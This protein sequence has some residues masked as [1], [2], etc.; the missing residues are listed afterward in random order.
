MIALLAACGSPPPP[1]PP[2]APLPPSRAE[3]AAAAVDRALASL[4]ERT[5]QADEKLRLDVPIGLA[6]V[7]AARPHPR[8]EATLARLVPIVDHGGDPRRRAWDRTATWP[9]D[10]DYTWTP[11]PGRKLS[12]NYPLVEAMYCRSH[13]LRAE[14]V[15]WVCDEL[16]DDGGLLSGHAAWILRVAVDEGCLAREATCLDALRD[17][18][19]AGAAREVDLTDTLAR[20]TLG[21]QILF[22]L[23]AGAEPAAL[24]GAVDRL[25]AV[26]GEDGSFGAPGDA[27][28]ASLHAT[29]VGAWGLSV[30]L[31][32]AGGTPP[33]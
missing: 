9:A 13:P 3:R 17:E 22:G 15:R 31:G 8:A 12:P 18:L 27:S 24:D 5:A 30:W 10:Q 4:D 23:L 29:T 6:A 21:E 16:R 33:R 20:D 1:P 28:F 11:T 32:S 25:L 26:Q 14:A 7:Q 2:P 19:V